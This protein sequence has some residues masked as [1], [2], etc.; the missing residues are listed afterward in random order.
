[1]TDAP[2]PA[3]P[4][5]LRLWLA[6]PDGA[7]RAAGALFFFV[8][9][10]GRLPEYAD[11]PEVGP[12]WAPTVGVTPG[13]VAVPGV[14][15]YV[16]VAKLLVDATF[17]LVAV[18]FAVRLPPRARARHARQI[19]IP[20]V[21]AFW[22]LLPFFVRDLARLGGSPWAPVLDEVLAYGPLER[23]GFL[24]GVGLVVVGNALDVWGYGT[25]LRSFSI[26]AEA[27]VLRTG[28]PY[29][30]V[31]HPIYLGQILAQA[32]VWLVLIERRS[33]GVVMFGAFAAMQLYRSRVEDGVLEAAFG[34][35]W[36]RFAR[37]SWWV[38]RVR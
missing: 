33:L 37:D 16:P 17:L 18:S 5:W 30:F 32:G 31:R 19:V 38:F 3:D 9:L 24:A 23:P 13:G 14:R 2:A 7:F 29:R 36:R 21:A 27:R 11:W 12:W 26:V 15:Q 10:L 20:V 1:M 22:P 6:V 25:L 4:L 8:F 35:A 34:E 28:G